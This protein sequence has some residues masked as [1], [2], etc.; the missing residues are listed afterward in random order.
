MLLKLVLNLR[1]SSRLLEILTNELN[2]TYKEDDFL[3]RLLNF[4]IGAGLFMNVLSVCF[5][6][7]AGFME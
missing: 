4:S 7:F 3:G 1:S 5:L 6:S 2:F